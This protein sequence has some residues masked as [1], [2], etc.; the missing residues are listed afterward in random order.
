MHR[1]NDAGSP[2]DKIRRRLGECLVNSSGGGS[3]VEVGCR[4]ESIECPRANNTSIVAEYLGGEDDA[5][6]RAGRRLL[7][8]VRPIR[9]LEAA[10]VDGE[11]IVGGEAFHGPGNGAKIV[12]I[13]E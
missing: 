11:L 7:S 6:H 12:G 2:Y 8:E 5:G 1:S 13:L 4:N 9:Y 3:R 10:N